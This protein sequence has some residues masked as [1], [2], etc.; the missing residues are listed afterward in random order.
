MIM[1]KDPIE[2]HCAEFEFQ[3]ISILSFPYCSEKSEQTLIYMQASSTNKNL[4]CEALSNFTFTIIRTY[5]TKSIWN[6]FS[7]DNQQMEL[8]ILSL[9]LSF[10]CAFH[11]IGFLS[12]GVHILQHFKKASIIK[13]EKEQ[14]FQAKVE[15]LRDLPEEFQYA[16]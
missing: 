7:F 16:L 3:H 2:V 12:D 4:Y 11:K 1:L 10:T 5:Q 15:S 13:H 6:Y 8:L 9:D 14:W